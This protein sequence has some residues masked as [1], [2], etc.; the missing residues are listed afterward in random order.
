MIC[1]LLF[2]IKDV[3]LSNRLRCGPSMGKVEQLISRHRE[4]YPKPH[5]SQKQWL[6]KPEPSGESSLQ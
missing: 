4:R 6:I 5:G 3:A 2:F 1:G